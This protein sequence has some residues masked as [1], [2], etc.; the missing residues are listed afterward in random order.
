MGCSVQAS[1]VKRV[2]PSGGV[3]ELR[4]R[5]PPLAPGEKG[6]YEKGYGTPTKGSSTFALPLQKGRSDVQ[7][8]GVPT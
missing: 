5:M 4:V 8:E 7:P 6:P 3:T 1:R 2:R